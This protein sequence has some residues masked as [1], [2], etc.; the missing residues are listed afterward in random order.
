MDGLISC[1]KLMIN[2]GSRFIPAAI[3]ADKAL[4]IVVLSLAV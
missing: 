2:K 1:Y 3:A 4:Y